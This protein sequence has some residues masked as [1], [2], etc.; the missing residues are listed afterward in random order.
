MTPS[1]ILHKLKNLPPDTPLTAT[2][3]GAI[4]EVLTPLMNENVKKEFNFDNMSKHQCITEQQLSEL[5]GES[6]STL[7]KWRV[8]G[9]GPRYQKNESGNVRYKAQEVRDWIDGNTVSNT[10]QGD[11]LRR[12]E[13]MVFSNPVINIQYESMGKVELFNSLTLDTDEEPAGYE[14]IYSQHFEKPEQDLA[15]WL[16]QVLN[17]NAQN[18]DFPDVLDS[19]SGYLS[20]GAELNKNSYI[21]RNGKIETYTL[22]RHV[23]EYKHADS[24]YSQFVVDLLELGLATD[25]DPEQADP[26]FTV[27]VQ[28]WKLRNEL[29]NKLPVKAGKAKTKNP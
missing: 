1:E 5:I 26:L 20:N 13:G 25:Y 27:A 22:S 21:L 8:K 23:S 3:I 4:L 2:H 12:L 19:I 6:V 16:F 29:Q 24:M 15:S 9:K 28:S 17:D 7:Q 18:V 11:Q 14:I 10:I